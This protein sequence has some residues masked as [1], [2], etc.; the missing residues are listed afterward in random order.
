MTVLAPRELQVT[1]WPYV[2]AAPGL[3]WYTYLWTSARSTESSETTLM[4]LS[5]LAVAAWLISAAALVYLWRAWS[6][7]HPTRSNSLSLFAYAWITLL[8]GVGFLLLFGALQLT[9]SISLTSGLLFLLFSVPTI[10]VL[11]IITQKVAT[12]YTRFSYLHV[13]ADEQL[14]RNRRINDLLQQAEVGLQQESFTRVRDEVGEPLARL[15]DRAVSMSDAA[16]GTDLQQFMDSSLRPLAHELHPVT[17]RLGL[18]SAIRSLD[19]DLTIRVDPAVLRMDADGQ[20]LDENVRLQTY[21]W[22]RESIAATPHPVVQFTLGNRSLSL[23]LHPSSQ[24]LPLDPVQRAAGLTGPTPGTIHI[25]LR[26]QVPHFYVDASTPAPRS[27]LGA[28]LFREAVTTPLPRRQLLVL[29][30]LA[31]AIPTQFLVALAVVTPATI[32]ASLAW[33]IIPLILT[34]VFVS[35]P[36]PPRTWVGATM[37][38]AEWVLISVA[39]GATYAFLVT[40]SGDIGTA[41]A[42]GADI[43]RGLIRFAIPGLALTISYG[44]ATAAQSLLDD[45]SAQVDAEWQRRSEILETAAEMEREVAEGLHRTVQGRVAASIVLLNVG[46]RTEALSYIHDLNVIVIPRLLQRL[47]SPAARAHAI[48]ADVP[49]SMAISLI[50]GVPDLP[51][52]LISD[53]QRVVGEAAVNARRHGQATAFAIDITLAGDVVTI[54]CCDDGR[55]QCEDGPAGLGSRVMDQVCERWGG[56]WHRQR[57]DHGCTLTLTCLTASP[58]A[59]PQSV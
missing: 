17:V 50:H 35:L 26:G 21:R 4:L 54:A 11:A 43:G 36:A 55:S 13:V 32:A 2:I 53:L 15:E 12:A 37:V 49:P 19:P 18:V 3:S 22:L 34:Q 14:A 5:G 1:A 33:V 28:D 8:A 23:A 20:L 59:T 38:I 6:R 27:R 46:Q 30:M 47:T 10:T 56:S 58:A 45:A 16:I 52:D 29:L 41:G 39:V 51:T 7:G 24:A 48:T 40:L 44:Y 25:P 31:G 9:R 42:L 57:T